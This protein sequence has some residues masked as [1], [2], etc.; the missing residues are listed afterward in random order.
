[1]KP[2]PYIGLIGKVLVPTGTVFGTGSW[3]AQRTRMRV[4]KS[5]RREHRVLPA[6]LLGGRSRRGPGEEGRGV[7]L[8][9]RVVERRVPVCRYPGRQVGGVD[10]RRA[11]DHQELDQVDV[12]VVIQ[13]RGVDELPVLGRADRGQLGGQLVEQLAV[14]LCLQH[15]ALIIR[16]RRSGSGCA[17]AGRA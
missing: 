12:L 5:R 8:Q 16:S 9:R 17:A 15:A 13:R 14:Q 7:E 4:T 6:V 3:I 10:E 11:V 1:M 2:M